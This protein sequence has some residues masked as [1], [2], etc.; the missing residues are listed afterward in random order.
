V[1]DQHREVHIRPAPAHHVLVFGERLE[2]PVDALAQ[3][4]D[5]HALNHGEVAH[6]QIAQRRRAWDD[7]EAAITH[8]RS[9]HPERGRRR[10]GT[11]P[12]DLR[13]VMGVDVDD[14]RHQREAAG[15]D[16]LSRLGCDVAN[17][18]DAALFDRDIGADWIMAQPVDH[19]RA[20]DQ[21]IVHI[22]VLP[23]FREG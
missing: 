12:G 6:D 19:R 1:P 22:R 23:R 8:H 20:A 18:G 16:R 17:R 14:P 2:L 21:Q 3:R 15:V 7:A 11:I 9:G 10:Q 4:L 13:V 5:V